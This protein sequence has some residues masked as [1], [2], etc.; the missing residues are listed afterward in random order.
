MYTYIFYLVLI[1][2]H[3]LINLHLENAIKLFH[4]NINIALL[5]MQRKPNLNKLVLLYWN[6]MIESCE[7]T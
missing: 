2:K 7:K 1:T 6:I 3:L 4:T 5:K